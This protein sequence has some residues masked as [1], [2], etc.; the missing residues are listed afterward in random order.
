MGKKEI[1]VVVVAFL[2]VSVG[3]NAMLGED[4]KD[5]M[6]MGGDVVTGE[7]VM[8]GEDLMQLREDAMAED[9]MTGENLMQ[10]REDVMAEDVMMGEDVDSGRDLMKNPS[11][12]HFFN[13]S[14]EVRDVLRELLN[15][16]SLTSSLTNK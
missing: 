8:I 9:V 16:K 15:N 5:L 10:I 12:A 13:G 3:T 11:Y 14:Y 6:Q 2:Y 4:V 7:D 1:L